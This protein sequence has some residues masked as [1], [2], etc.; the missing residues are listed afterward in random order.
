MSGTR[1]Y[2]R[3]LGLRP[4]HEQL[5]REMHSNAWPGV[6]EAITKSG[7][8]N[9]SIYIHDGILFS[10]F[11]Y[12]GDDLAAD[13]AQMAADPETQRWWA[14]MEPM[15]QRLPNTPADEWWHPIDEVFHLD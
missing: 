8:R 3:V 6:L 4:E 2:A 9:Y 5:Y 1:R 15:Q 11:E 7:I 14:V 10:Y 13:S 12:D